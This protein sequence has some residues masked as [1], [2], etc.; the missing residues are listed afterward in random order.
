MSFRKNI[1]KILFVGVT[2]FNLFFLSSCSSIAK[3]E[4]KSPED[5]SMLYSDLGTQSLMRSE[6]PQ[7]VED[8]RKA[9]VLD[10]KNKVALN[11]IGLAYYGL[12]KKSLAKEQLMKAIEIDPNYSDAY[13]NLAN[14]ALEDK[15]YD[16]AK[17]YLKKALDN[18]EY[19]Y[20]HRA[21][22]NLAQIEFFLNN[23]DRARELLYQSLQSNSEYCMTHFLLGSIAM[24]ENNSKR[25]ADEFK[26]SVAKTCVSNVEGHYQLG[27]AYLK[28][29]EFD[30]A[31][32]VFVMLIDQHSETIQGQKASDQLRNIP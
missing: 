18:L 27:L 12:G 6:F 3:N 17:G 2:V 11:H 10:S 20:R 1:F 21:L 29:R 8:F 25:A 24:R 19:K 15:Q 28:N 22:T 4:K 16:Q 30:K 14:F 9:L 31:R 13:I 23:T 26:K 5:L 32:N 7:A